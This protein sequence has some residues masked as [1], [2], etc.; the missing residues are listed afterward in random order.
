MLI[1][2]H[3]WETQ[4]DK[5]IEIKEQRKEKTTYRREALSERVLEWEQFTW[6]DIVDRWEEFREGCKNQTL[7][8][9]RRKGFVYEEWNKDFLYLFIAVN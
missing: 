7:W 3:A 2:D 8:T 5:N 1:L 9:K 6:V 4:Q